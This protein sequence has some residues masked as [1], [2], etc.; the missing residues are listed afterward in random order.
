MRKCNWIIQEQQSFGYFH[1][2]GTNFGCKQDGN[3][4]NYTD[5]IV[6]D[7]DGNVLFVPVDSI[8]FIPDDFCRKEYA[9]HKN[10]FGF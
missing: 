10:L 4:V 8:Q 5:A 1:Q 3:A 9:E 6:E 7:K 2:F